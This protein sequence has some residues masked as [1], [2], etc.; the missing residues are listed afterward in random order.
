MGTFLSPRKFWNSQEISRWLSGK[1]SACQRRICTFNPWVRKIPW[2]WNGNPLQCSGLENPTEEP[3]RLQ[4]MELQR[5]WHDWARTQK[6]NTGLWAEVKF[7]SKCAGPSGDKISQ[8]PLGLKYFLDENLSFLSLILC[9]I[10]PDSESFPH[11]AQVRTLLLVGGHRVVPWITLTGYQG[12]R[13]LQTSSRTSCS[14]RTYSLLVADSLSFLQREGFYRTSD[15]DVWAF[16]SAKTLV[17]THTVERNLFQHLVLGLRQMADALN[18]RFLMCKMKTITTSLLQT[19]E[20]LNKM[21]SYGSPVKNPLAM[22]E[23]RVTRV[24]SLGREDPL[25][26]EM[27]THSSILAWKISWTEEPGGWQKV[28]H[29]LATNNILREHT[30][31]CHGGGEVGDWW[32]GSLG[33]AEANYYT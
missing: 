24:H 30:Y 12:W 2:G 8:F 29:N 4:S 27:A 3:G 16:A 32:I 19:P 33:L 23:M 7:T 9:L 17:Y 28:R 6:E 25:E 1:E 13:L 18:L 10:F 5:V 14:S 31:G 15:W 11:V 20:W 22:Q 26:E 21:A